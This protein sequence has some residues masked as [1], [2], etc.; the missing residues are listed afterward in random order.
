M[1][2]HHKDAIS[3]DEDVKFI[4]DNLVRKDYNNIMMKISLK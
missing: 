4:E 2:H 1:Y 3:D